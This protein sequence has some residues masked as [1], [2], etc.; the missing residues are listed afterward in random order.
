MVLHTRQ[1]PAVPF[2]GSRVTPACHGSP[3][4]AAS[5]GAW[6]QSDPAFF[7]MP[8]LPFSFASLSSYFISR[9]RCR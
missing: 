8:H 3:A 1:H 2:K 4:L 5:G 9:I 7:E 6:Q